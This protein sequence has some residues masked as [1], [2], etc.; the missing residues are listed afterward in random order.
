MGSIAVTAL[1][2]FVVVLLALVALRVAGRK[3]WHPI[4]RIADVFTFGPSLPPAS[5]SPML[6]A[7]AAVDVSWDVGSADEE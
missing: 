4:D 5:S 6:P 3:G 1:V 2:A 7:S